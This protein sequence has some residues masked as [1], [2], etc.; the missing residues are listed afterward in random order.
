LPSRAED[1]DYGNDCDS[2]E[3]IEANGTS[4]EGVLS[5]AADQD[6]FS[7]T[8]VDQGLYEIRLWSQSG[9]KYLTIYGPGGCPGSLQNIVSLSTSGEI[10]S[11]VF[12]ETAGTYYIRATGNSGLYRLS[13][14]LL[15]THPVDTYPD[16]CIDPCV[17]TVDGPCPYGCIKDSGIDEDWFTFA[18]STLHKYRVSFYRPLNTDVEYNL[19]RS[20]CGAQLHGDTAAAV[21]FVSFDAAD[22][23]LRVHSNSFVKEGYYEICVDDLG[24]QPDDHNN[25]CAGATPFVAN[26]VYVNGVLD[27]TATLFS[28]EDWFGF[29][30]PVDGTYEACLWSQSGYKHLTIYGPDG[31]PDLLQP[32]ASFS[33][34]SG[35]ICQDVALATAGT[36]YVRVHGD[37]GLYKV[38]VLAPVPQCGD[39]NHPYPTGDFSQDCVVNF[40]D[41]AT[42]AN[43]W[44]EDNR[45]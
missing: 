31:C 21:T 19:Y 2:A 4:I 15:S 45:P 12:I 1:P 24:E 26:G 13:V 9:Y 38:S 14:D 28:D 7:F 6:W 44:L 5:N 20:D 35:T 25:N 32:V 41:L 22:Y 37:S 10:A 40:Y 33:A 36:Y 23:D 27:Y 18:T 29:T 34:Y 8:A 16:T 30:A 39:T 17:L 43:H 42:F 11:E 3:P